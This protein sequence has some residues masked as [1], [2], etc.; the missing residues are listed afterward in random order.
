MTVYQYLFR[1][2]IL[3]SEK[4]VSEICPEVEP[5]ISC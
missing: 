3:D 2:G 4:Q 5:D 1:S